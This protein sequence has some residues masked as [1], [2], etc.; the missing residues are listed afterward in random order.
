MSNTVKHR[1]IALVT[2]EVGSGST[3]FALT[4]PGPHL[5]QSFDR[6][7]EGTKEDVERAGLLSPNFDEREYAWEPDDKGKFDKELAIEIRD[8]FTDDLREALGAGYRLI[9]WDKEDQVWQVFR[10]AEF[11]A[12]TGQPR[13][14]AALNRRYL[15]LINMVKDSDASL[16]AIDSLRTPWETGPNG[17]LQKTNRRERRGFDD[18]DRAAMVEI[19]MRRERNSGQDPSHIGPEY[20]FDIGKCRQNSGLQD[21]TIPAMTFVEFG[22]LLVP[23][24][25]EA[26]W[27]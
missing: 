10:Y 21:Q 14:F 6:G 25:T 23:G 2:S 13:D 16:I 19:H 11:G 8:R 20:Y 12:E 17:K 7:L 1:T 26:E 18:L 22:Q 24:S 15:K 9:T 3:R 5:Y 27:R 4:G